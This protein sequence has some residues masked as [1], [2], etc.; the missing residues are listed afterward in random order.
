MTKIACYLQ[1]HSKRTQY[2]KETIESINKQTIFDEKVIHI[3][4][5]QQ[6]NSSIYDLLYVTN[7]R[8][9][10]SNSY[11]VA[12]FKSTVNNIN[13]EYIFYIEDDINLLYLPSWIKDFL[14]KEKPGILSLNLGGSQC[15]YP[16]GLLG[17]LINVSPRICFSHDD[18]VIFKRD[19][20][21]RNNYYFEFPCLFMHK[22]M[23]DEMMPYIVGEDI[24]ISLTNAYSNVN[25]KYQKYSICRAAFLDLLNEEYP[26]ENFAY[27]M[28]K[29]KL[30][31]LLDPNQ[32]GVKWDLTKL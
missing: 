32:G 19:F 18:F 29:S 23:L 24:E 21:L 31:R 13:A 10:S 6:I 4:G 8:I 25:E 15:D 11:R 2:L 26:I 16:K 22:A 1:A 7:W 9:L 27:E 17:D 30:Y 5:S 12:A 20:S 14:V 3:A 28:E